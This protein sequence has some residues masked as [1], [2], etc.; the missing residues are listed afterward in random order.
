MVRY[1]K[2][3]NVKQNRTAFVYAME[4]YGKSTETRFQIWI[5][6]FVLICVNGESHVFK[7]Q[8]NTFCDI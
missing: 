5:V 4:N 1:E 7:H 2:A 3:Y 6:E 8:R